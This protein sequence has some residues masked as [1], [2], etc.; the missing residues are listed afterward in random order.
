ML[1]Q[2]DWMGFIKKKL[3]IWDIAAGIILVNEAGGIIDPIDVKKIKNHSI[4]ASSEI[5]SKD[6][7]QFT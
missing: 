7:G 3:N 1:P 6:L 4:I 2:E 5:I